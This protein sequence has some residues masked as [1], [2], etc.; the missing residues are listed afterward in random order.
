[1]ARSHVTEWTADI[2]ELP[3]MVTSVTGNELPC[4]MTERCRLSRMYTSSAECLRNAL[5][6]ER[7]KYCQKNRISTINIG[8]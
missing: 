5:E 8:V 1:M 4:R 3:G 7:E 6:R 2:T